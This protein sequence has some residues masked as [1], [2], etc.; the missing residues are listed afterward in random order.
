MR[1]AIILIV[2]LGLAISGP[3]AAPRDDRMLTA[4]DLGR[5]LQVPVRT[6]YAFV[7]QGLLPAHRIGKRLLRFTDDDLREFLE[8]S[9]E[10]TA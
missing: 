10:E 8:R 4:A 5:I 7:D 2:H 9:A 3:G 6:V 1:S